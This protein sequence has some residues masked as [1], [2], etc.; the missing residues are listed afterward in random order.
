VVVTVGTIVA[1]TVEIWVVYLAEVKVKAVVPPLARVL[2]VAY[3]YTTA[4]EIGQS[5]VWVVYMT[6]NS[7]VEVTVALNGASMVFVTIEVMVDVTDT[8]GKAVYEYW[9]T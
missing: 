6:S 3:G 7:L 2:Q 9:R 4:S 5:C 1:V 8:V